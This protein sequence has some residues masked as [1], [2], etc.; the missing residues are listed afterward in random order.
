MKGYRLAAL[1]ITTTF[2][3][4]ITVTVLLPIALFNPEPTY[5]RNQYIAGPKGDPLRGRQIYVREGCFYCHSQFTRLQDRGIGTLV[6]AGDYALETPHQL[7]TARTGPDLTNEGMKY[8]PG[9]QKAHLINPRALKPGSIMPSFSYLSRTDM[10]DLV[11]YI[12]SLGANRKPDS[13]LEAPLEY[14]TILARKT[15]DTRSDAAANAGAGIYQQNCLYCHGSTGRGNGTATL[16]MEKKPANFT[17]PFYKQ[18]SDAFWF[19]R[20][21][22]GVPGT[23]MPRW[24]ETLSEEQRWY[25]VAY[26]KRLPRDQID[27]PQGMSA[28]ERFPTEMTHTN[29]EW[30]PSFGK[31]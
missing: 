23:R 31:H 20:I 10:E 9:W 15:V 16:D 12:E 19:Y 14:R 21:S 13:W 22:E 7:G 5:T 6:K 11:S 24:A 8:P 17:N 30:E 28:I 2:F 3:T 18:Y 4:I 1:G 26:I 25:L 27:V 29:Q